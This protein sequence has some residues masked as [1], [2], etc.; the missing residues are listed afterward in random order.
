MRQKGGM[1]KGRSTGSTGLHYE[2]LVEPQLRGDPQTAPCLADQQ[3]EAASQA[4]CPHASLPL[5]R[6]VTFHSSKVFIACGIPGTQFLV[7]PWI[8]YIDR[9]VSVGPSWRRLTSQKMLDPWK[10]NEKTDCLVLFNR[11]NRLAGPSICHTLNFGVTHWL[12]PP[13]ILPESHCLR[14]AADETLEVHFLPTIRNG[15][16]PVLAR[17]RRWILPPPTQVTDFQSRT[18]LMPQTLV[19][20]LRK[21]SPL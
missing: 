3:G 6:Q 10:G 5:L 2:D 12:S 7:Q 18:P 20:H 9:T 8:I 21:Q 13:R 4:R 14:Q 16:A 1:S 11:W 17:I 15:R 19:L